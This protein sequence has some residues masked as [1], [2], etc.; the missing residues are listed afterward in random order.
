MEVLIV[1]SAENW[2]HP[3]PAPSSFSVPRTAGYR[4]RRQ[5]RRL[6]ARCAALL[7]APRPEALQGVLGILT[8]HRVAPA[9]YFRTAPSWNVTPP[10]FARQIAGL[11]QRGY[12]PVRLREALSVMQVGGQLPAKSFVVTFD[13]G[14]ENVFLHAWPVLER[15]RVPAT[16]FLATKYLD[17]PEPFPFEDWAGARDRRVPASDWRPLSSD[18]CRRMLDVGG[19]EFGSHTHSHANF[20]E[21]PADLQRDLAQSCAV[22]RERFGVDSPTFSFPFGAVN[23]ALVSVVRASPTVCGLTTFERRVRPGDDPFAWGR[24]G[25]EPTDSPRTLAAKLDGRYEALRDAARRWAGRRP[26]R[27]WHDPLATPRSSFVPE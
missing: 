13:D 1:E 19:V 16:I 11:L 15:Y 23:P 22:L 20:L 21:R 9:S 24:F 8:Y 4:M 2:E 27:V 7:A 17:T 3:K 14:Y 5:A 18:Q 10:M 25:V 6:L 12:R 26:D